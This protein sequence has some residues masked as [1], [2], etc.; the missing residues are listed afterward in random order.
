[1]RFRRFG[2]ALLQVR[3]ARARAIFWPSD[4]V[5]VANLVA[6]GGQVQV[7]PVARMAA[8]VQCC[9]F[10]SDVGA[11]LGIGRRTTDPP[12]DPTWASGICL[13]LCC[14]VHLSTL[15]QPRTDWRLLVVG[16]IRVGRSDSMDNSLAAAR[17]ARHPRPSGIRACTSKIVDRLRLRYCSEMLQHTR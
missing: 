7:S 2:A 10:R 14:S 13:R 9:S 11:A 3:D 12:S 6:A 5:A 4:R 16:H 17:T 8:R 1:M 15:T